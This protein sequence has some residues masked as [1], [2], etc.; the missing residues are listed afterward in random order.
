MTLYSHP[1]SLDELKTVIKE[2]FKLDFDFSLSYQDPDF[3]GQLCSLLD[4]EELNV[5]RSDSDA[6]SGA[7]D[8]TIIL[9]HAMTDGNTERGKLLSYLEVESMTFLRPLLPKR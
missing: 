5:I 6:S 2:Q 3:N 8:D 4:T 9:I 1:E 7:S